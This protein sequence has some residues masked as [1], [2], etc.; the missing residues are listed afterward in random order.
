MTMSVVGLCSSMKSN[1]FLVIVLLAL[2]LPLASFGIPPSLLSTVVLG[3]SAPAGTAEFRTLLVLRRPLT[4][5]AGSPLGVPS[6]IRRAE[7]AAASGRGRQ[8]AVTADWIARQ[9][10]ERDT[11][12]DSR[13]TMQMRLFDRQ[14]RAR[15][16]TLRVDGLRGRSGGGDRVLVRFTYPN[17]IAGTGFLVWERPGG[18]DDRFLFLP[19]LARVR[20]ITGAERQESFVGSDFT[21]EDIG[22]RA[23]DDYTYTLVQEDGSWL[24]SFGVRH[25]AWRLESKARDADALYPKVI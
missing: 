13:L 22:G 21:Y 16:R 19:A 3:A 8:A 7:R 25:P 14:G 4:A 2:P 20:R 12:R 9:V 17:D 24:D 10:D 23:L 1:A 5:G 11:G 6:A 15:E 18:D